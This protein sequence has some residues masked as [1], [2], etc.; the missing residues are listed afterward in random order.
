MKYQN[1]FLALIVNSDNMPS[2]WGLRNVVFILKW[3]SGEDEGFFMFYQRDFQ[4][5][6]WA[7]EEVIN[8]PPLKCMVSEIPHEVITSVVTS[9]STRCHSLGDKFFTNIKEET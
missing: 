4:S 1:S 2:E 6:D 8:I 5:Y 7:T 9:R 3:L